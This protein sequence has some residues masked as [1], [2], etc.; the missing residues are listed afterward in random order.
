MTQPD[1]EYLVVEDDF[2]PD[3]DLEAPPADAFE[4]ALPA[5]PADLRDEPRVPF[6]TNEAD[7]YEQSQIVEL[8][9]DY[10]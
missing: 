2:D 1:E 9:D 8:D 10:R 6:E 4:Q 5:N 7:A 3:E